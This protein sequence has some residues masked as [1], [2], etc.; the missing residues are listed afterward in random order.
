MQCDILDDLLV[1]LPSNVG[2]AVGALVPR[3]ASLKVAYYA[4]LAK[5]AHTLVDGVSI[6]IHSLAQGALQIWQHLSDSWYLYRAKMS[7]E[8]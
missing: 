6:T 2:I 5:S 3:V 4:V 8:T 1:N 7:L